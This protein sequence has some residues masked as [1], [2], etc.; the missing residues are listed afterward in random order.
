MLKIIAVSVMALGLAGCA[1]SPGY[2][3]G[4]GQPHDAEY[5][6][7]PFGYDGDYD[8]AYIGG[9]GWGGGYYGHRYG[10]GYHGHHGEYG[11]GSHRGGHWLS[12]RGGRG[13]GGRGVDIISSTGTLHIVQ[14]SPAPVSTHARPPARI[15]QPR[16]GEC[17]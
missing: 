15:G 13:G 4:Y 10:G 7:D 1:V 6:S 2:G 11:G 3:Y 8:G 16:P 14:V 17:Q 9:V 12:A 5:M